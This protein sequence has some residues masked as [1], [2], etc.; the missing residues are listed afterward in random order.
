MKSLCTCTWHI[1][2]GLSE[3][4]GRDLR[5][6]C[7]TSHI[8]AETCECFSTLRTYW[9]RHAN[10][11]H[12]LAHI[13]GDLPIYLHH[14]AHIRR[15]MRIYCTTWHLFTGLSE[16]IRRSLP[17]FCYYRHGIRKTLGRRAV[18]VGHKERAV[19]TL[20]HP[21]E[22]SDCGTS[23]AMYMATRRGQ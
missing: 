10:V 4:I 22:S 16:Y 21:A 2:T 11:L 12:H 17:M 23:F 13:R 15:S 6:F 1:F 18:C 20:L 3:Y 19:M 5:M 7:T 8:L 9:E 14:S